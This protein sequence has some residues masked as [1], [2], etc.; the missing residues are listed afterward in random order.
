M[1]SLQDTSN[2]AY[3]P[4]MVQIMTRERLKAAGCLGGIY[5][6]KERGSSDVQGVSSE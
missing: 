1:R 3:G 4:E 5:Y 6:V 2:L